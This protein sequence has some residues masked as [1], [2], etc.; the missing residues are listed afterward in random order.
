MYII[1]F[2]FY[3]RLK[4]VKMFYCSNINKY[5]NDVINRNIRIVVATPFS[6]VS[7]I[8]A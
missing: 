2:R 4:K 6:C 5:Q 3:F 1:Y 8:F 7:I